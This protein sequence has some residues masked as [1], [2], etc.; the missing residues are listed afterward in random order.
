MAKKVANG[1]NKKQPRIREEDAN[2]SSGSDFSSRGSKGQ[3]A[4]GSLFRELINNPA[5]RYAAGG[6]ATAVLSRLATNMAEKYPELSHFLRENVTSFEGKLGQYRN[7]F[8]NERE[9][10]L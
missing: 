3:S 4:A 9:S 5:V 8:Q 6:I 10:H 2:F 1:V 7:T